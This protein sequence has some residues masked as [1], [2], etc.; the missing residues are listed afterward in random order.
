MS[1]GRELNARCFLS[2]L[3]V[4]F[5]SNRPSICSSLRIRLVIRDLL[6]GSGVR[7]FGDLILGPSHISL[8]NLVQQ[9]IKVADLQTAIGRGR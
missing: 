3:T 5:G 2:W 1:V 6:V 4:T 9:G 7:G 8:G